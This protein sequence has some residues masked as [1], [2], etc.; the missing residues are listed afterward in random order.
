MPALYGAHKRALTEGGRL[1][2]VIRADSSV[3]RI[4][5]VI[6]RAVSSPGFG[7]LEQALNPGPAAAARQCLRAPPAGRVSPVA[8]LME[9]EKV[10]GA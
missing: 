4:F 8:R 5:T 10:R 2:L 7:S 1:W 9:C 6:G 3:A